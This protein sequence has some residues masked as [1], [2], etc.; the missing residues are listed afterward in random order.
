MAPSRSI[1]ST[2][3][4]I[5]ALLASS[6]GGAGAAEPAPTQEPPSVSTSGASAAD[7][8][9]AIELDPLG[10]EQWALTA[11]GAPPAWTVTDGDGVTIAVVDTG[12][13]LDHPDLVDRL[14]P[15]WDFVDGDDE[16]DDPHGHGTHVAGIAAASADG[17]GGM[18]VAPAASIMPLRVLDEQ[19]SGDDADIAAAIDWAVEHG[20]DVINLSLG[21]TGILGRISKG[22]VVN[23]SI[24]TATDA[25]VIVVAA[26]GNEGATGR[27]YRLGVEVVVVNA[28]D[29]DGT[30]AAFSNVG[31]SRAISAPGVDILSTAPIGPSTL[32]PEGSEGWE[33][34]DGTSM[35]TPVVAGVA[36]LVLAAGTPPTEVAEV[37]MTTATPG[38]DPH[39]GAGIVD[40]AAALG[41]ADGPSAPTTTTTSPPASSTTADPTS[42][43]STTRDSS[44][45]STTQ[46]PSTSTTRLPEGDGSLGVVLDGPVTF[47]GAVPADVAC[48]I[49]GRRY[50]VAVDRTTLE[51]D[52]TLAVDL[53]IVG[54]T[55]PGEY[56]AVGTVS[57]DASPT[58]A[59]DIPIAT[60]ASVTDSGGSVAVSFETAAVG[61]I[62]VEIRWTCGS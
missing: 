21:D 39:L 47:D 36:A 34:L 7:S 14:V 38:A 5:L 17:N 20:A 49:S 48:T 50:E 40:A 35:A 27:Q 45:T 15:G 13:D 33:S 4:P 62:G 56:P 26:S 6:C 42:T 37:L 9:A 10:A 53:L 30:V 60:P 55:G 43:T 29:R 41:V 24:R 28:T 16:P 59:V 52:L 2:F 11:I 19:G 18:G 25:G 58:G 1:R 46:R 3:L 54:Y 12:V 31:D 32:W 44:T 57:I 22:G 51:A 61:T 8:S 23:Q